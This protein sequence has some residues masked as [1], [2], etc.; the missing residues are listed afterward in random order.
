MPEN[1]R[2][3]QVTAALIVDREKVLIARRPAGTRHAGHWEFPGG[4]QEP[5]ETLEECVIREI[6]EELGLPVEV[7]DH[8]TSVDHDYGDFSLTLHAFFCHPPKEK[9]IEFPLET[10]WTGLDDLEK[11]NFLPPDLE[12][13]ARLNNLGCLK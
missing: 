6:R 10:T 12:I 4:K 1:K 8:F 11:Y 2:H 9:R 5:G 7:K 3:L 13:I